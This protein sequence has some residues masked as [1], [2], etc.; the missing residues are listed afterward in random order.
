M[1]HHM[2][3]NPRIP[4]LSAHVNH[5]LR[6]RC[7][8]YVMDLSLLLIETDRTLLTLWFLCEESWTIT[9]HGIRELFD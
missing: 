8:N 2:S 7:N 1:G 5:Y 4:R 3:E 6:A 9:R